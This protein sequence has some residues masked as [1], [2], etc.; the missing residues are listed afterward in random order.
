MAFAY[1]AV[2]T[3]SGRSE[4]V[5]GSLAPDGSR[6]TSMFADPQGAFPRGP[7]WSPDGSQILFALDPTNDAFTHPNNVFY[8][9]N[10]NGT[11]L[12]LINGSAD[13]KAKPDW[14]L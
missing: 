7:E 8:L 5:N 1:D 14:W 10:A 2:E 4:S 9:I 3:Y 6:L 11:S 12:Q 13:F